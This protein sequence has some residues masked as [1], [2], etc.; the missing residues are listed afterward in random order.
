MAYSNNINNRRATIGAEDGPQNL[1]TP[2]R[3]VEIIETTNDSLVIEDL[4]S[5]TISTSF[6]RPEDYVELHIYNTAD[7]LLH[8]ETNFTDFIKSYNGEKITAIKIDAEQVLAD[9]N[10]TSGQYTLKIHI[11]R[12][13]IFNTAY[14]PFKINDL[15]ISRREIK[16]SRQ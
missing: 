6:G 7:Q 11:L 16:S 1:A 3:D 12:N 14:L 4:T 15:S 2:S 13:K 8:S 10:Y 9:R 5:K